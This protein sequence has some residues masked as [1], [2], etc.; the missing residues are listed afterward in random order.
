MKEVCSVK[1]C[2]TQKVKPTEPT[3]PLKPF[4]DSTV[5]CTNTTRQVEKLEDKIFV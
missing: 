2:V 3:T 5:C 1:E 4:R